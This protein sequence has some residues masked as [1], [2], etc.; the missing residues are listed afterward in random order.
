MHINRHTHSA[1]PENA[2]SASQNGPQGNSHAT[3]SLALQLQQTE[4]P[5]LTSQPAPAPQASSTFKIRPQDSTCHVTLWT[6]S[7]RQ[8]FQKAQAAPQLPSITC[9]YLI[10]L[11]AAPPPIIKQLH[12]LCTTPPH[13]RS[14]P[15]ARQDLPWAHRTASSSKQGQRNSAG[16]WACA[17]SSILLPLLPQAHWPSS[18]SQYRR[19]GGLYASKPQTAQRQA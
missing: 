3:H 6:P 8:P 7:N 18:G 9:P 5:K 11:A 2:K 1:A 14:L 10:G 15:R 13:T 17:A 12:R 19:L 16:H 4:L